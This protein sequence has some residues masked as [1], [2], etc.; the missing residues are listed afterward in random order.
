MGRAHRC[1]LRAGTCRAQPCAAAVARARHAW[2]GPV[3]LAGPRPALA[4]ARWARPGSGCAARVFG[5]PQRPVPGWH[6]VAPAGP[7]RLFAFVALPGA[8]L[9][10]P[11]RS[12]A[13]HPRAP[14]PAAARGQPPAAG[15]GC[16]H[17]P[18]GVALPF[19]SEA[20]RRARAGV[21]QPAPGLRRSA[22]RSGQ[23]GPPGGPD[24]G[25]HRLAHGGRLRGHVARN[26]V[27]QLPHAG[28]AG[29]GGGLPAVAA[30]APRG[31]VAGAP[32]SGLRARHP[33]EPVANA[34]RHHRHQ[35]HPG[36]QPAQAGA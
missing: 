10:E 12:G 3:G 4:P 22:R 34:E 11:A 7:Q 9:P 36:L 5:R 14:G 15:A 20:R 25:P 6:F 17:E 35:H 26:R 29:V 30:L 1:A 28:D 16:V 13:S 23:P 2:R 31:A 24:A 8:G 19:H 18:P 27:A 33:L 32:V 21:A